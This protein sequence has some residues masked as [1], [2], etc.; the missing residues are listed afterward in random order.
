MSEPPQKKRRLSNGERESISALTGAAILASLGETE[1]DVGSDDHPDQPAEAAAPEPHGVLVYSTNNNVPLI[2]MD[3]GREVR[4]EGICSAMS[5]SFLYRSFGTS[6]GLDN[7]YSVL[8]T[9]ADIGS[10]HSLAMSQSAFMGMG[11]FQAIDIAENF[12]NPMGLEMIANAFF[13]FSLASWHDVLTE[14]VDDPGRYYCYFSEDGGQGHAIA[15]ITNHASEQE[16]L[17]LLDPNFGLYKTVDRNE[18]VNRNAQF[19]MQT[20]PEYRYIH[21]VMCERLL[22]QTRP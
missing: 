14:V 8:N 9:S 20:Y 18:F 3:G 17:F 13:D 7:G 2:F 12:L 22:V 16:T 10:M 1:P 21:L 6:L 19:F 5:A 4:S 11:A 15:F